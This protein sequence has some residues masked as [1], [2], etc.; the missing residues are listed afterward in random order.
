M[1]NNFSFVGYLKPVKDSEKM[2]GFTVK[3]FNSGWM[4]ER[5]V[6]NVRSGDNT[7]RVE[8]NSGRWKDEKKNVIYGFTKGD[9]N[10]KGEAVK[11]AWDK[12]NDPDVIESM[13][14][15]KIFTVETEKDNNHHFLAGTEFC[16]FV[17]EM[18]NSDDY[19]DAKFEVK[20]NVTYNYSEKNGRYYSAYEV[21]KIHRVDD[22]TP[23]SDRMNI[24][25]YFTED[26]IDDTDYT[27]TGKAIVSGYTQ[28]YD[29]SVKRNCFAPIDI[30][31]RFG[32]DEKGLETLAFWK[33]VFTE[34]NDDS[35]RHAVLKCDE[36]N[37]TERIQVTYDD[38]SDKTKRA[39]KVGAK[40]LEDALREA[41]GTVFGN[42]IQEIRLVG[43]GRGFSDAETTDWAVEDLTKKPTMD[44]D[45]FDDLDDED[46]EL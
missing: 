46:D 6:F 43:F 45:I 2:K 33:D 15:W 22:D 9:A 17:N 42:K 1:A 20:G 25:F 27:E 8:I 40:K 7:H 39:I 19:K 26:A 12:R 16:E 38:L 3:D 10:T 29:S 34:F 14:G 23:V 37:G 44:I 28:Y 32:T 41:G 11:I 21:N 18:I 31:I 13:A 5:L 30:A 35:V 24:D 4:T 36:I